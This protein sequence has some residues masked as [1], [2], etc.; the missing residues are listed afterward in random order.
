[1]LSFL[2]FMV[3][4]VTNV[5]VQTQYVPRNIFTISQNTRTERNK[6][7]LL[8]TRVLCPESVTFLNHKVSENV[9]LENIT[10]VV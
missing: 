1:M 4:Y 3:P 5:N 7:L 10:P 2:D 8:V 9:C 6:A